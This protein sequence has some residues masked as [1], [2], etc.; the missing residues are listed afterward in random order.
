MHKPYTII[1][2]PFEITSGGIRVMWG[3]YGWL[4][5]KGQIAFVNAKITGG[6]SIAIYPEIMQGNPAESTHVVRYILQKPGLASFYGKPGPKEFDKSDHLYYF[7]KMY[8]PNNIDDN[9][10]MFLP[11]LDLNLFKDKGKQRAKTC[12]LVG[13]GKNTNVHPKDSILINRKFANNQQALADLL[14]ECHTMY[15]Y[16]PATAMF[17]VARLCGCKVVLF[18]SEGFDL[19]KYEPGLNGINSELDVKAFRKHYI[20]MVMLFDRKIDKFIRESQSW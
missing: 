8:A 16:D 14:N 18:N 2:P 17:E 1:T 12:Y 19:S 4:L 3:L 7:S 20:E 11:I 9:H 10:V 6:E 13:K 5:S 15:S